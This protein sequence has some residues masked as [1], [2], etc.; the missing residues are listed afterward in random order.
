MNH[1]TIFENRKPRKIFY[2]PRKIHH[3]NSRNFCSESMQSAEEMLRRF[4]D[5][6][7]TTKEPSNIHSNFH[8]NTLLVEKKSQ[9]NKHINQEQK[10]VKLDDK[11]L[12]PAETRLIINRCPHSRM[13]SFNQNANER[14]KN[15]AT[16]NH[17]Y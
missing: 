11:N 14:I 15:L 1:S 10:P 9:D 7:V 13:N 12:N 5:P 8:D 4:S 17:G 6:K 16:Q 2:S 3:N